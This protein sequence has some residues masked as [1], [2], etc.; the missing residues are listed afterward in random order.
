MFTRKQTETPLKHNRN[1]K[2]SSIE[3][4]EEDIGQGQQEPES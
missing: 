4:D 2:L 1:S 3:N